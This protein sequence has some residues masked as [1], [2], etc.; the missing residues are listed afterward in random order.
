MQIFMGQEAEPKPKLP[1]ATFLW[2]VN[3]SAGVFMW[4]EKAF[5]QDKCV[6]LSSEEVTVRSDGIWHGS[7]SDSGYAIVLRTSIAMI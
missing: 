6:K 3:C 5:E 1:S 2:K 4:L 7:L